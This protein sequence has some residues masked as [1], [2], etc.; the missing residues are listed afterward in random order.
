MLLDYM[1]NRGHELSLG[2]I[3]WFDE[4]PYECKHWL[5]GDSVGAKTLHIIVVIY[6]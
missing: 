3:H 2:I 1:P 5:W 6:F 4:P